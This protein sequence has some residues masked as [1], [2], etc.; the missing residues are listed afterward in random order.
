M[1]FMISLNRRGLGM[2]PRGMWCSCT[3]AWNSVSRLSISR[4]CLSAW[5]VISGI[6]FRRCA[7]ILACVR[8]ARTRL[9]NSFTLRSQLRRGTSSRSRFRSLCSFSKSSA[10][11]ELCSVFGGSVLNDPT[12]TLHTSGVM[13]TFPRDHMSAP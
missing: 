4:R 9:T 11:S 7:M 8:H 12:Y 6:C 1:P 2:S 3:H 13:N 5:P 10:P